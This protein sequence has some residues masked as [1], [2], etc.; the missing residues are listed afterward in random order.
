MWGHFGDSYTKMKHDYLYNKYILQVYIFFLLL[1]I[2][3]CR[4]QKERTQITLRKN[5]LPRWKGSGTVF[6]A[7]LVRGR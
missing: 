1:S 7:N 5:Y 4:Q 2:F 3:I 6:K